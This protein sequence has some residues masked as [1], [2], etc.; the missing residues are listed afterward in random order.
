MAAFTT[1]RRELL[2]ARVY[3]LPAG[4]VVDSVT[5]ALA[6]PW[7][8]NSPTSNYTNYQL[9]DTETLKCEREFEKETFKIPKSSGGY[10]DDEESLL[11][12]VTY[13]GETHKTNSLLKQIE[14]GLNSQPVVGTAQSPFVRND[15]YVE[16]VSLIELQNK[17]GVVTE[18]I[19]VWSRLRLPNPGDIGTASKKLT[20]T[21]EVRESA[22]NTYVL[23]A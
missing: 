16:G 22:A 23:V 8:D 14:H 1:T 11:K 13:T 15:D 9:Q 12:K 20:Y 19:Q 10:V 6:G 2:N 18:R 4:E 5:V 7:P 17:T 3:F 21:L